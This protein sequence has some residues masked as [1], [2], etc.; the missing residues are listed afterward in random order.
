MNVDITQSHIIEIHRLNGSLGEFIRVGL[1]DMGYREESSIDLLLASLAANSMSQVATLVQFPPGRRT[2][3]DATSQVHPVEY[4]YRLYANF[5][6]THFIET[7]AQTRP[8][9]IGNTPAGAQAEIVASLGRQYAEVPKLSTVDD[10][11]RAWTMACQNSQRA[12]QRLGALCYLSSQVPKHLGKFELE[13]IKSEIDAAMSVLQR[14]AGV[15]ES[16]EMRFAIVLGGEAL[17]HTRAKIMAKSFGS[18]MS[19]VQYLAEDE[20]LPSRYESAA[21]EQFRDKLAQYA[22]AATPAEMSSSTH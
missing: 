13:R 21:A 7:V 10:V 22:E 1:T 15:F 3:K 6:S 12:Y 18:G 4:A 5:V 17:G 19:I 16:T 20:K 9:S 14:A 8:A 2:K 11:T